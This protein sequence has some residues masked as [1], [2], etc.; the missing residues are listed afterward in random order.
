MG[1]GEWVR[2]MSEGGIRRVKVGVVNDRVSCS[3]DDC[4]GGDCQDNFSG[5]RHG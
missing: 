2:G 3:K 4:S 5:I 1:V